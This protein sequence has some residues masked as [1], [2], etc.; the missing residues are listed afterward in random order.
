MSTITKDLLYLHRSK[1]TFEPCVWVRTRAK[2]GTIPASLLLCSVYSAPLHC[3]RLELLLLLLFGC[4][5]VARAVEEWA[6]D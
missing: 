6:Q 3:C 1:V 4:S 2:P 5:R